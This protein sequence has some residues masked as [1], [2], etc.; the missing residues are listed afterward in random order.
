[1]SAQTWIASVVR[2]SVRVS[3]TDIELM[4]CRYTSKLIDLVVDIRVSSEAFFTVL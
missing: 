2:S 3:V 1:M 4:H